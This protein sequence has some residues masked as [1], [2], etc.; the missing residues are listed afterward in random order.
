MAYA[1]NFA[2]SFEKVAV[3]IGE[4]KPRLITVVPRVVEKVYDSIYSKG[5]ALSG[6]AKSLFFWALRLGY[7]YEPYNQKGWW[8]S[9]KLKIARKLIFSKW[10]K[11]LGRSATDDLWKCRPATTL[12]ACIFCGRYS[13]LG[14]IWSYGDLACNL[15]EL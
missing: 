9:L 4:V 7:Q 1:S 6:I 11:A 2:E 3:N 15:S 14:R 12:G 10:K 8:Y 13:D 5:V